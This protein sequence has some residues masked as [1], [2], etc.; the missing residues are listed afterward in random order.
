MSSPSYSVV[1]TSYGHNPSDSYYALSAPGVI[2]GSLDILGNLQVQ[3]TTDLIG[4][5]HCH[6]TLLVDGAV[7]MGSTLN[8]A[9]T[10]TGGANIVATTDISG[11]TMHTGTLTATNVNST[12]ATHT[13]TLT[14]ATAAIAAAT[15]GGALTANSID[16]GTATIS[17]LASTLLGGTWATTKASGDLTSLGF[18]SLYSIV[19]GQTRI[20][21][22][23][24]TQFNT[25][26][27][28][29]TL[30]FDGI[31]AGTLQQQTGTGVYVNQS[32]GNQGIQFATALAVNGLSTGG[33]TGVF[34]TN[35]N[36]RIYF[37]EANADA[38]GANFL[39]IGGL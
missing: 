4:A 8:V 12:N 9:G 15:I 36:S 39:V 19:L 35:A 31:P 21:W 10:I 16:A 32:A 29:V 34:Y 14:A 17:N 6:S 23:Y 11:A 20:C 1:S 25:S 30:Q 26:T 7:T 37:Q 27:K 13:G 24:T 28:T 18:N 2:N 3:G 38:V 22:G 5:V 33:I